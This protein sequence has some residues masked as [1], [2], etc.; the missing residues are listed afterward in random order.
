MFNPVDPRQSLPDLEES[1]LKKWKKEKTFQKSVKQRP[2]NKEYVFYDGPPFAT[3]LPHYGHI[4]AGTLKDVVPRYWTM[5]GYRVERQFGWDCHGLPVEYEVEKELGLSGKQDIEEK[6]GVNK[7]CEKCRS[8]VTRYTKEWEDTVERMGR[9]VDFE[10]D[11]KTM[12][13]E[14]ME[15]IWWVFSQLWEKDLIYEGH[16]SMHV[17]PRCVTPLSNF[18][19]TQGYKD[20][21]DQSVTAKFKLDEE[22]DTYVLAWTTTPWTLAGNFFLALGPDVAYSKVE[23]LPY[24]EEEKGAKPDLPYKHGDRFILAKE[25]LKKFFPEGNYKV[26]ETFKGK[27][28]EGKGYEPLFPYYGHLKEEGGFK[29]LTA[30]FVSTEEGTGIVHI[31]GGFG[32]DDM[33]LTKAQDFPIIQHVSIDGKFKPEVKDFAGEDVK[34][35]DDGMKTDRKIVEFLKER[36][37]V[38]EATTYT[39][40]YPHCWRCDSP[41]LNYSTTSWFMKVSKIKNKIL[42][43]NQNINWTPNHLKDGRFGQWLENARDWCISRSRYW[44]APL[45]LWRAKDGDIIC[46]GSIRELEKLSGKKVTDLHKHKVDKIK[47]KKNGKIYT[48]IPEVLDCWFESGSMPYAQY[49]YPFRNKKRF[50]ENFPAQFIAEGLDQT[51]GWFYTL[52]VLGTAL[53]GKSPFKNVIVNG[54]VLAEDGKKMSKRLKNYPEPSLIFDKH[55]ADALRFYLMNSPVVKAENARFSEKGVEEV[56]KG[57][58]LP[59]WNS[60]SFLVTYANIDKWEPQRKQPKNKLDKWILSELQL[61]IKEVTEQMNDYDLQKATDPI[62]KFTDDLTNWYIRRSRRRFWKNETDSDKVEAYSTLYEVLTTLSK[63]TAPFCPFISEEIYTNLTGKKSVH[64]ENWPK[65]KE[66]LIDKRLSREI[67]LTREIVTL[68]HS[69]RAQK[70]IKVRQPLQKVSIALPPKT[71]KTFEKS[72]VK[73]ELNVKEVEILKDA[74]KVAE[75]IARPNAQL[76]GPKYG[77]EVQKIIKLAREGKFKVSGDTVAI[78]KYKL[79]G[80]EVEL[81]YKG[82]EG[83]DVA[84]EGGVV[85]AMDTKITEEL[86]REGYARDIVRYIQ[87]MRKEADYEISDYI[88]VGIESKGE[89]GK[90]VYEFEKYISGETLA[91]RLT[92]QIKGSDW[93][94]EKEAMVDGGEVKIAIKR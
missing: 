55:G 62:K 94:L 17:C 13:P 9:W 53:F 47:I 93:D 25:L 74:S 10:N 2:E 71:A 58:L 77:G 40:S 61:L 90:A 44:G 69:I 4:L 80:D 52:V 64:L 87:D 83:F 21:T 34:P 18:E 79:S 36:K 31:A 70:S 32:E 92:T 33:V 5:R 68:G 49:S 76:L 6:Y 65:A 45:P 54:I 50:E 19:V 23:M 39:H 7:F 11:Y 51:R 35:K 81:G 75:L 84:S 43:S 88:L 14:Y 56:V 63:V 57:I 67:N 48:R 66:S 85:V 30:D 73:E 60:Y 1:L 15:T 59:I 20:V 28:L 12:N 41:L 22:K 27:K 78:G 82:K 91:K 89:I 86:K 16:K 24:D 3:G 26:I 8:I 37:K 29:I 72:V 38:F 46:I 42:K